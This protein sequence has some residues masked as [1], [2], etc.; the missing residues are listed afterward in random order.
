MYSPDRISTISLHGVMP[1]VFASGSDSPECAASDVWRADRELHRGRF[2]RVDASSG[3][4][5]TSLCSYIYGLRTD[6][7]GRIGFDGN[8]ISRFGI[9]EW[10][11]LRRRHLAYLPQSLE[12]FPELTATENVLLKNA[13]TDTFTEAEIRQMFR[14]LDVDS[15]ADVAA[16]RLSVG[17]Q[18][19]V[20]LVRALCQPFDFL[21]LDEPVSH[22]DAANNRACAE[23][24]ARTARARGAAVITTSVGNHLAL[25]G[26][27]EIL[28]L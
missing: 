18:Q 14:Q 9:S 15:R 12:L 22:L 4:G 6:Y 5:K 2:Y 7:I 16:A 21:L 19:R 11:R 8:D 28:R 26:D 25:D 24:V 20:A 27:I 3:R 1:A 13:L 23:L 10:C 17:Q